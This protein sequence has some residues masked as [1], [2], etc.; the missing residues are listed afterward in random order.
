MFGRLRDCLVEKFRYSR[1]Q[2]YVTFM[3]TLAVG[4]STLEN[5]FTNISVYARRNYA[6]YIHIYT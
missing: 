5:S 1:F 3:S 6:I 4:S 2:G